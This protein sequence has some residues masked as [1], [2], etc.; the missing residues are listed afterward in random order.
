MEMRKKR[1]G[2]KERVKRRGRLC[3]REGKEGGRKGE[4]RLSNWK[5][6]QRKE[7]NEDMK[8]G[9]N[10]KSIMRRGRLSRR[11]KTEGRRKGEGR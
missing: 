7:G 11:R 3:R 8:D 6:K 10:G 4:G 5:K 1:N 9:K 2:E